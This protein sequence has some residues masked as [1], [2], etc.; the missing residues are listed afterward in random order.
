MYA[1]QWIWMELF[2]GWMLGQLLRDISLTPRYSIR[3]FATR[4]N[5][6]S[7]NTS[8][9]VSCLDLFAALI[10]TENRDNAKIVPEKEDYSQRSLPVNGLNGHSKEGSSNGESSEH[11]AT[12]DPAANPLPDVSSEDDATSDLAAKPLPGVSLDEDATSDPAAKPSPGVQ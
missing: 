1:T 12:S 10:T 4:D 5:T 3:D 8:R 11:N 6:N 2:L 7:R 9:W